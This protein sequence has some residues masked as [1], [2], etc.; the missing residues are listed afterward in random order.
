MLGIVECQGHGDGKLYGGLW[1]LQMGYASQALS[2]LL[3]PSTVGIKESLSWSLLGVA[4]QE[5]VEL[6]L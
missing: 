2:V 6:C 3:V 5:R 1:P 4:G